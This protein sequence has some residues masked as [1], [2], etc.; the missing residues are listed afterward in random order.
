MPRYPNAKW[1]GADP[2]N[3][4]TAQIRPKFIVCHVMQGSEAGTNSWFHNP[5]AIVSAHFGVSK[6][7]VVEQYVD[8]EFEAYAEMAYNGVGISVE[9]EGYSGEHL[10]RS[11]I[12]A[13]RKLFAWIKKVHR[14]PLIWRETPYG[15]GGVVSHGELGVAGGD[16]LLCPGAPII[17]DIRTLLLL[18]PKVC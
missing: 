6:T 3:Y 16:H 17:A 18:R 9:H 1:M 10:T 2:K 8:T 4:S 15:R 13:D 14:I 12:E 5:N 11:Q 7:G